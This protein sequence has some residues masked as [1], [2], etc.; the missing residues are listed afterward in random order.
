MDD[1]YHQ[2]TFDQ[3]PFF[4][5]RKLNDKGGEV[6]DVTRLP[7]LFSQLGTSKGNIGGL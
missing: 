4:Q 5:A 7:S 3:L 1:K 2:E 6:M